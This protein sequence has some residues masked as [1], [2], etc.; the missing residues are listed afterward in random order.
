[1]NGNPFKVMRFSCGR[2]RTNIHNWL[3]LACALSVLLLGVTHVHAADINGAWAS[4]TSVCSKVFVKKNGKI[5]I[6]ADADFYGSGFI[7]EG[8]DMRGK[9]GTCHIKT[10]KDNGPV[11][12]ILATCSTDV[13][14]STNQFT[15]KFDGENKLTRVF[16]GLPGLDVTYY[17][18]QQ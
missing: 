18:C 1:V 12:Q 17:R 4:D 8:K 11:V 6:A 13:A 5:S 2:H 7:I 14:L 10:R 15:L 9:I 3:V 16:T